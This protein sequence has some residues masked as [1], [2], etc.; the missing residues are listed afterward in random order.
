MTLS[1][2]VSSHHQT[3]TLSSDDAAELKLSPSAEAQKD[4]DRVPP[5]ESELL[6]GE[7]SGS[8]QHSGSP[9]EMAQ[10]NRRV[11]NSGAGRGIE[12]NNTLWDIARILFGV[13]TSGSTQH[14]V[15]PV[16]MSQDNHRVGNSGAGRGIETN[17]TLWDIARI[18]LCVPKDVQKNSSSA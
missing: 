14:S 1:D 16:E 10:D 4:M 11:G 8:T 17:N 9:V 2:L 6:E 15:S 3:A 5:G 7:S 12:T 18:L 13:P